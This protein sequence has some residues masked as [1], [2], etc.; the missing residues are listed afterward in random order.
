MQADFGT[1]SFVSLPPYALMAPSGIPSNS[2]N[3]KNISSSTSK[4]IDN[5]AL[6]QFGFDS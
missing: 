5:T 1:N 3:S 2:L 4:I 6:M